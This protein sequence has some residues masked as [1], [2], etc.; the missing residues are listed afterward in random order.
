MMLKKMAIG[1]LSLCLIAVSAN[2]GLFSGSVQGTFGDVDHGF[3]DLYAITNGGASF[4]W[5][6]PATK[7]DQNN[8]F[9]FT[10]FGFSNIME[11]AAFAIGDFYYQN[12]S[13]YFSA[14]INAVKLSINMMLTTPVIQ[15]VIFDYN[16]S[17]INTPNITGNPVDDGDIV[18][19]A[20]TAS[21]ETFTYLGTDY[22]LNLRGFSSDRGTTIRT[23]FSSPEGLS[24]SAQLFASIVTAEP[25][26]IPEPGIVS[27]FILGLSLVGSLALLRRKN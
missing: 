26:N 21:P 9:T 11:N 12:G 19:V 27:L 16:F 7:L 6:I 23:D 15:E 17:L 3:G 25:A 2:A 14:G 1:V 4:E 24:Q 13:T 18:T 5:G 10:G 22:T 8:R 20:T